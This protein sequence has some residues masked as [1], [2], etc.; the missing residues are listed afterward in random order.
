[1]KNMWQIVAAFVI[2]FCIG[3]ILGPLLIP[4]L[5]RLKFGQSI[6]NDGPQTHLKKQGTPTMGGV[7]FFFTMTLGGIF[8]AKGSMTF[9]F[10]LASALGFGFIGFVDDYIKIVKHR[11]LGLTPWQ[12]I[13]MQLVIS[14]GLAYAAVKVLHISTQLIIPATS[15]VF[16]LGWFYIPFVMFLLI[17]TTN[18]VNLTDG[19][20]GLASGVTLIVATGFG[21][22]GYISNFYSATLFAAVVVG[23]CLSFLFFNLH[24]AKIF[25]GD[26]G[27]FVLGGAVAALAIVTKTELFLPIL[28]AVYVAEVLSDIIQVSV[29]KKTKKRVFR[30]APLHHHFE[31]GGWKEQKV[32]YTF[33]TAAVIAVVVGLILYMLTDVGAML[34]LRGVWNG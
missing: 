5:H 25:M 14:A 8:L 23:S 3:M 19:L 29:Y 2:S 32:V 13:A 6:R 1:M 33:W 4:A 30:M 7:I 20:D 26:T 22:I 11:S 18:A 16:D 17:G 10:L 15:I 21:L 27:S 24:P 12:K 34:M 28:G 9:W 31:L